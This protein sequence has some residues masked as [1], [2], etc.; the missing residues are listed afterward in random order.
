MA[1][2]NIR[3]DTAKEHNRLLAAGVTF[4]LTIALLI[5]LSIAIYEKKFDTVTWVTVDADRAGLQL[6]KFGDVRINGALVGQVRSIGEDGRHAV[7]KLALDPAAAKEIPSNVSVKI[8]PTTLFG[9]KFVD[10]VRPTTPSRTPLTDGQVIP[11][12]RVTTN[13]ELSQVLADLFP[14]LRAV[15]PADLN[16]TLSAIATALQGRGEQIGR[17]MDQL[18]SYLHAIHGHLPTLKKDMIQ[19]AKVS[20]GYDRAAPDLLSTLRN[21]TVTSHT[22]VQKQ[23]DI[24]VFFSDLTGLSDTTTRVLQANEQNLIRMGQVTEPVT[25]LL[26]RYSPEFPCLIEGAA[27]YAPI[28]SK[29]FEGGWVKQYIEFFNPQYHVFRA[30]EGIRFGEIGHGPW[31]LGLPHFKVPATPT[32]LKQGIHQD[33]HPPTNITPLSPW[34]QSADINSGPVGSRAERKVIDAM[35][36]AKTGHAASSYGA[37]G[38]VLYG[39]VIRVGRKAAGS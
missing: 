16:A 8:M 38:P 17:T 14:L 11:A 23:R 19:L 9:Q 32:P 28:L 3:H 39:P 20:D 27:N 30:N 5:W 10:L 18:G 12:S 21:L 26:A 13:V 36:A 37:L 15:R 22:I 24:D 6:A 33:E 34:V 4:I 2:M 35:L 1:L 31:C 7:I 25:A 29:T